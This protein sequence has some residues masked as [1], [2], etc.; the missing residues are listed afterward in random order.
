[1]ETQQIN[2][3]DFRKL[4]D[5]KKAQL[6][7][8]TK[9]IIDREMDLFEFNLFISSLGKEHLEKARK[10][11]QEFKKETWIK[12]KELSEKTGKD[13]IGEYKKLVSFI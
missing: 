5:I 12:A 2:L 8:T 7:Q 9:E 3:E 1:M 4:I 6:E 10:D 13:V 11:V